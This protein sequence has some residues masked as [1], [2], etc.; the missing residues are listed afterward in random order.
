MTAVLLTV[1]G[2]LLYVVSTVVVII[3]AELHDIW[4]KEFFTFLLTFISAICPVVNT[5]CAVFAIRTD[6]FKE[7]AKLKNPFRE[8]KDTYKKH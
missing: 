8:I 6:A 7:Y 2:T 5:I 3:N 4:E 1:L